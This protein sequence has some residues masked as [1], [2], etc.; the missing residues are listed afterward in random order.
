[1]KTVCHALCY[2][3]GALL[4]CVVLFEVLFLW[5]ICFCFVAWVW[6]DFVLVFWGF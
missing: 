1:M 4:L 6:G 2:D 3:V 5:V